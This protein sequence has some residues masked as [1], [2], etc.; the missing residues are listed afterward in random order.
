MHTPYNEFV[1]KHIA[2]SLQILL[3]AILLVSLFPLLKP[4]TVEAL[5][6]PFDNSILSYIPDAKQV[7]GCS[8]DNVAGSGIALIGAFEQATASDIRNSTFTIGKCIPELAAGGLSDDQISQRLG[9]DLNQGPGISGMIIL[10]ATNLLQARPASGVIFAL[11]QVDKVVSPGAV[12]AQTTSTQPTG[13]PQPYFPGTGYAL[14]TPIQSFWGWAA[15]LSF[16]FMTLIIIVVAFAMIFRARLGGKQVVQIQNAIPGIVLAMVLIPLSYPI[17]GLFIDGIT[18]STNIFH[19]FIFGPAGPGASVYQ[20]GPSGDAAKTKGSNCTGSDCQDA[21]GGDGTRGLYGDDWR[22]SSLRIREQFG[23]IPIATGIAQ[24]FCTTNASTGQQANCNNI[25]LGQFN[26]ID[27]VV[28][29]FQNNSGLAMLIGNILNLIF[30]LIAI[31]IS[32]KI[33]WKLIKKFVT[34]IFLPIVSPFIFA[35]VAIPGRGTAIMFDY[36]KQM[37][38]AALHFIVTYCLFLV[39]IVFANPAFHGTITDASA[40]SGYRPPVLA[41]WLTSIISVN[42]GISSSV[43]FT[44][45]ALGLFIAIPTILDDLDKAFKTAPSPLLG[46]IAKE[47]RASSDVAFRQVPAVVGTASRNILSGA[48][49]GLTAGNRLYESTFKGPDELTGQQRAEARGASSLAAAESRLNS[50]LAEPNSV[51]KYA[52]VAS[53]RALLAG[54]RATNNAVPGRANPKGDQPQK[55]SVKFEFLN[56]EI[57]D[58]QFD[59]KFINSLLSS[60]KSLENITLVIDSSLYPLPNVEVQWKSAKGGSFKTVAPGDKLFTYK[61]P[62]NEDIGEFS[63]AKDVTGDKI[64]PGDNSTSY[65]LNCFFFPDNIRPMLDMSPGGSIGPESK[66]IFKIGGVT[67]GE[68]GL[69]L[70]RGRD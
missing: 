41:G 3:P 43:I 49:R 14:L 29:A 54:V 62:G 31:V 20:V 45:L 18:L 22:V 30:N 10:S 37:G 64:K 58:L 61:G 63:I 51:G 26:L 5:N 34:M 50:A 27:S 4:Q 39:V 15:T 46:N 66:V 44:L 13:A 67:T 70:K 60:H 53:A 55:V 24:S 57:K 42:G 68:I 40:I 47:L 48:S 33:T 56:Q 21:F 7:T 25:N 38:N 16:S 59:S 65:K 28:S 23:A 17:S 69:A 1:R 8:N 36:F 2:L 35:T 32:L 6:S 52:R 19:D 12:Y 9:I 11:D